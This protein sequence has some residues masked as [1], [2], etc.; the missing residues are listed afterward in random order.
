MITTKRA[1]DAWSQ[2][3]HMASM[4]HNQGIGGIETG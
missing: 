2:A 4:P 3:G 1:G